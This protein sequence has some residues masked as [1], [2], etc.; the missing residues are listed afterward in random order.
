M[1][2]VLK[3]N[4]EGQKKRR[5]PKK[6]QR[7][8]VE[9]E[10]EKVGLHYFKGCLRPNEK[11]RVTKDWRMIGHPILSYKASIKKWGSS[12]PSAI[13]LDKGNCGILLYR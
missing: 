10:R 6:T 12:V 1:R 8:Q 4:A 2:D 9:V 5:L 13:I 11:E 7:K 3:L